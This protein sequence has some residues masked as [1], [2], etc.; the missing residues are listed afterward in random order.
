MAERRAIGY[1]GFFA[2]VILILGVGVV[3]A[4]S[5]GGGATGGTASADESEVVRLDQKI[6]D[7]VVAGDVAFIDA[8]LDANFIMVHG[9]GWTSG[10]KPLLTD[11]KKAFLRRVASKQYKVIAFDSVKAEMH[12]DVAITYGRYVATNTSVAQDPSR[13]WFSV[14]FERVF[15]KRDGRW[16]YLSHRTVH[17]PTYGPDRQ[18]VSDK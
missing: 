14:W 2:A 10:G 17:G 3:A 7:A 9:D 8:V 4:Q 18:S 12:G 5:P 11:D 16:I 15:A 1:L 13:A 6:A